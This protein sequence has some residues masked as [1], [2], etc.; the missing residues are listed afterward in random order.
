MHYSPRNMPQRNP[1]PTSVFL[2][3]A[4][5]LPFSPS[6][7][8]VPLRPLAMGPLRLERA[9]TPGPWWLKVASQLMRCIIHHILP[10][11]VPY[12]LLGRTRA[13]GFRIAMLH[14]PHVS[15]ARAHVQQPC[16]CRTRG[17]ANRLFSAYVRLCCRACRHSGILSSCCVSVAMCRGA[18]M[19]ANCGQMVIILVAACTND[20]RTRKRLGCIRLRCFA[21]VLVSP[22]GV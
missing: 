9:L 3:S 18:T 11:P 6:A 21:A 15:K 22:I 1:G 14:L 17:T 12:V 16:S 2:C 8:P 5:P 7:G 10:S 20:V 19:R 13:H 4:L